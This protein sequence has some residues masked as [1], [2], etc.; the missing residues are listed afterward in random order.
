MPNNEYIGLR[1]KKEPTQRL[2]FSRVLEMTLQLKIHSNPDS[3]YNGSLIWAWAQ[4]NA[5]EKKL[6]D[7]LKQ[8]PI[9]AGLFGH[10]SNLRQ[11]DADY[12]FSM[13]ERYLPDHLHVMNEIKARKPR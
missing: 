4:Y 13:Q 11:N 2:S 8:S 5:D 7:F 12:L 10:S 3:P 1:K 6:A 9:A